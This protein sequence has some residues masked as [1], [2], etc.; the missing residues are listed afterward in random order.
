MVIFNL[1]GES[2]FLGDLDLL[3]VLIILNSEEQL[4]LEMSPLFPSLLVVPF[5]LILFEKTLDAKFPDPFF[6]VVLLAALNNPVEF[7][8]FTFWIIDG[9][10]ED[11]KVF[12]FAGDALLFDMK[13]FFLNNRRSLVL[14]DALFESVVDELLVREDKVVEES[15]F[16][17]NINF[18]SI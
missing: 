6:S 12:L 5:S 18:L 7:V 2:E 4:L 15:V 16:F 10:D 8:V 1:G 3:V 13:S 11:G 14:F 17:L 9:A